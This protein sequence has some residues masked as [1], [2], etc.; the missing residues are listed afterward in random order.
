MSHTLLSVGVTLLSDVVVV[1]A[2]LGVVCAVDF[3]E[4]GIMGSAAIAEA[5]VFVTLSSLPRCEVP[6]ERR[7]SERGD[8]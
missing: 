7:G 1:A 4:R 8:A 5:R 2:G 3:E 6:S